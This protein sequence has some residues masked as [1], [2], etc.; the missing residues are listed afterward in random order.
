MNLIETALRT[1]FPAALVTLRVIAG[2]E[3]AR[4][5]PIHYVGF[6]AHILRVLDELPPLIWMDRLL[7]KIGYV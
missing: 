1:G 3:A 7:P 2:L 6:G 4:P 5:R